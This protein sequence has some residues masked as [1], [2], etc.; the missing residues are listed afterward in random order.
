M[1]LLG[2]NAY[3][4]L[5]NYDA[6]YAVRGPALLAAFVPSTGTVSLV[7]LG[8]SDEKQCQE[9]GWVRADGGKLYVSCSGDFN[10]GGGTAI[11]EV[12]PSGAGSVSRSVQTPVSPSGLAVATPTAAPVRCSCPP[13]ATA[14][15][16]SS[17]APTTSCAW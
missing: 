13:R 2:S 9:A 4:A 11:V 14:A 17:P 5:G 10:T 3:V 8:G 6:T 7:D 12:D 15:S 16:P 1:T